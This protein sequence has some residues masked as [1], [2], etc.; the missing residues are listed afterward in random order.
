[1]AFEP[2]DAAVHLP[3]EYFAALSEVIRT[4]LNHANITQEEKTSLSSWWDAEEEFLR[5][6]FYND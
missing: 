3:I 2:L 5:E 6:E 1:M 4:G